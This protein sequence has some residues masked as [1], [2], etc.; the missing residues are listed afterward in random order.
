MNN[1]LTS[2]QTL[3][4]EE[5]IWSYGLVYEPTAKEEYDESVFAFQPIIGY[6][7]GIFKNHEF[8]INLYG[9]Y[10]PGLTLDWKHKYFEKNRFIVS[11]DLAA[12]TGFIRPTGF[13]YDLLFGNRGLYGI[14]G[15]NYEILQA[16]ASVPSLLIGFGSEFDKYTKGGFQITVMR[17]FPEYYSDGSKMDAFLTY[18]IGIK[19]DFLN[20]KRK[21]RN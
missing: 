12:F 9:I 10:T 17:S 19:F 6:R 20:T 15:V 5:R 11:G 21:Y 18:S 16:N 3:N 7:S 14:A 2:P 1:R 4:K 13:Q 8:G